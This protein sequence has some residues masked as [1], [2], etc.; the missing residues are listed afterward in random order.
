ME[1]GFT[2]CH[3]FGIYHEPQSTFC[4]KPLSPTTFLKNRRA[5]H[6]L[7]RLAVQD[8]SSRL[9]HSHASWSMMKESSIN[10]DAQNKATRVDQDQQTGNISYQKPT[11]NRSAALVGTQPGAQDWS[12]RAAAR[13]MLRA[14]QFKDEDFEKPIITIASTFTNATPCNAHMD[15][16]GDKLLATVESLGAKGFIFGTPVI[17]D[18]ETMGTSGMRYSLVSRDL[19]ADC[20]ECMH[21][22]YL[23]D[24]MLT[25]GGC[26]KSIPGALMPILRTNAY[27][28]FLYGGSI[29]PG[30]LNGENLTV[31]STF[32][33][34]GSYSSGR[35]DEQQLKRI[36]ERAC[37]GPGSCGG[38]YTA[39]TMASVIEAMGLSI[40]YSA[41]HTAM[42]K[43]NQLSPEKLRDCEESVKA[44]FTCMKNNI[45]A[46]DICTQKAFENGITVMMALGGSTNGVL[47]LLALAHEA[48]VDLDIEDFNRIGERVPL[49][50]DFKPSGRYVMAD[51]DKIGGIPM[52]MK[53][54]WKH[55]LIHGDCMTVT[56]KRIE[57]LL[58]DAPDLPGTDHATPSVILPIEK[59]LAPAGQHIIIMR[60]NLA[61]EGAVIKL[62]GKELEIHR[63]PARVFNSEEEALD[64][65]L[66]G[67]IVKNDV[68]V[69]R[70]EGPKGGP[71]MR[72][73][74]SPSSAIMGSGLGKDV[75]L[76]TDGR[77]SGGTH[78]I[79][80]GHVTPEAA[81][82]GPIALVEE[83]DII[84]LEPRKKLMTLEVDE[85]ELERRRKQWKQVNK[86]PQ[87]GLLKK[88]AKTV[89]SA[90]KGAITD[91]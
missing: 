39:N 40:P 23:A 22:G 28:V 46:R 7:P 18:G 81:V 88:Y 37:P 68:V 89:S 25:L 6:W 76:I 50:G 51:L 71:G 61:P 43:D 41:S 86:L 69:I 75:A 5:L 77:F 9:K 62:S 38:M 79:M 91:A 74:L 67:R 14:I 82:G 4:C 73:M 53:Y 45:R 42:T 44:L 19:I 33:A 16:L 64:A 32:E 21:E 20:I 31:I 24:G 58:A 57:E 29:Q 55:G 17:S 80:V 26:D 8:G 63:G 15:Q 47:H 83:G 56:G 52:V 36:E 85:R 65:I 3:I 78:G 2:C 34:I 72:E 13:S 59:A 87:Q 54:L 11:R 27:G 84:C 48:Q 66:T 70:Y 35:I 60:G 30:N 12:K 49:L 90:S 10:Q 1:L